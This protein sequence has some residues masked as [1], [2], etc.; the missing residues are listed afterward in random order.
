MMFVD[1]ENLVCRGQDVAK[2]MG[3]DLHE[4]PHYKRDVFLWFPR[5]PPTLV[6]T[7]PQSGA[8]LEEYAIRAHYY[9]S[10]TAS[11][12]NVDEMR[13]GIRDLGFQPVL[14]KKDKGSRNVK[15]VDITLTKDML[16][17][18]FNDNYDVAVLITGD[19]DFVPVVEEVK[20]M[21][22]AVY[23]AFFEHDAAGLSKELRLS[24]DKFFLLTHVFK[25]VWKNGNVPGAAKEDVIAE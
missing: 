17:H 24:S 2:A 18:A 10:M 22:K 19:G 14:F 20:R 16:A 1:G 15:G 25:E 5:W 11:H 8:K 6:I 13:K 7:Q 12:E 3:F 21:G 9:T 4:G 23:L